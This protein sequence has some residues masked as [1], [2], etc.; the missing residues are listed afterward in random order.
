MKIVFKVGMNLSKLLPHINVADFLLKWQYRSPQTFFCAWGICITNFVHLCAPGRQART[1]GGATEPAGHAHTQWHE[2]V[3][4][5]ARCD[6][7]SKFGEFWGMFRLPKQQS[8]NSSSFNYNR[9]LKG[10]WPA[11]ALIEAASSDERAL[12]V[13]ACRAAVPSD[14]ALTCYFHVM[15]G[16]KQAVNIIS[17]RWCLSDFL[18]P[19][20]GTMDMT[21][22]W[23][24]DICRAPPST[25]LR[26]LAQ[27]GHCM[28]KL[29]GL[30]ASWQRIEMD[31]ITT[32]S[33]SVRLQCRQVA[34]SPVTFM[35]CWGGNKQ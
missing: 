33:S 25:F 23:C 9:D 34:C 18:C 14:C 10:L 15:M 30:D 13:R 32:A 19:V 29:W 5:F 26:D 17:I 6:V 16:R 20:G 8:N 22:F 31:G 21:Q 4:C 12:A 3:K 1:T 27:I 7:H 2:T 35:W 11:Q 24:T 28:V